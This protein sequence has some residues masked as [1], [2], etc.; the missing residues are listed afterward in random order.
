MNAATNPHLL[1]LSLETLQLIM[2]NLKQR[3]VLHLILCN[4]HLSQV[5]LEFIYRHPTFASTYRLAQFFSI[6][7]TRN[8]YTLLVHNLDISSFNKVRNATQR[9]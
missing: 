4:K 1:S 3:D 5:M 2:H 8:H 9:P 6:I 7:T